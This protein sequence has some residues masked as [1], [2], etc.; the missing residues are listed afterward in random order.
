MVMMS[1][2]KVMM[3]MSLKKCSHNDD[4]NTHDER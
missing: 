3:V 1:Q 4:G 2:M